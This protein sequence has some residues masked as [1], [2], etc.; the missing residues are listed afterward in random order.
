MEAAKRFNF[1]SFSS[2]SREVLL[3]LI[4][5]NSRFF[6]PSTFFYLC[7]CLSLFLLI[8][9]CFSFFLT[10]Y[11]C[12]SIPYTLYNRFLNQ[13]FPLFS[14]SKS[15]FAFI[16]HIFS[17][18][19]RKFFFRYSPPPPFPSLFWILKSK[20]DQCNRASLPVYNRTFHLTQFDSGRFYTFSKFL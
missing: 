12:L 10:L 14:N 7:V 2:G 16:S 5:H 8:Y 9:I 13:L 18:L 19:F 3:L 20:V 1:R 15:F 11:P 17:L 6:S 4:L